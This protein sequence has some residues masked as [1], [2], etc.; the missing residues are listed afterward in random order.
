MLAHTLR[1]FFVPIGRIPRRTFVAGAIAC[2]VVFLC[3]VVLIESSAG[4]MA[5]VALYP[6]FYWALLTLGIKR[7]HDTDQAGSRL[8]LFLLPII[9]PLWGLLELTF[10]GG[11]PDENRFGPAPAS[12]GLDYLRVGHHSPNPN[13]IN[14]VTGIQVVQVA[15]IALPTTVEGVQEALNRSNGP[16][17]IGGGRFSM[18]G[19]IA[20]AGSLHIDMRGLNKVVSINPIARTVRV[21]AGVRWCDLQKVLDAHDLSVR[22]M[23]TYA[24][25]TVGGSL[26]VNCHGRYV[27]EGPLIRSVLSITLCMADGELIE[28]SP[29]SHAELFYGAIGGYGG[30][31]VV[32]E[33]ELSVTDNTRVEQT[34]Q[35]MKLEAYG[36]HFKQTVRDASTAVFHNADLYPPHY[37]AMRSVTWRTTDKYVTEPGRL[38]ALKR[39]HAM[40][41]YLFWVTSEM[42]LGKWRRQHIFEPLF[43]MASR[44]HWR[45]YEAGY[46]VA[47]LEPTSRARKTYVLQEYFVPVARFEEFARQMAEVFQRYAVNVINVS[48][49]H[50]KPDPG[51][52]LAWASEECFAFVVYYKQ[53][54]AAY[55]R[56]EVAVWTRE[57]TERVIGCGGSYYLPYQPHATVDQFH[58]AYPRAKELFALK[59]RVDPSNRFVN[60]LWD[61]YYQPADPAPV[62]AVRGDNEF[63]AIFGDDVWSDRF[64]LFLQNVYG[65]YPADRFHDLIQQ[66]CRRHSKDEAI[67][68]DIQGHLAEI[69]PALAELRLALPALRKQKRE[70]TRQ[71]LELL[72]E[73]REFNGVLE[74]GSTG[75]YVSH[76]REHASG[77]GP[78]YLLNE[79]APTMSPVD[80]VE[81]GGLKIIGQHVPMGADYAPITSDQ[82]ADDSLDLVTCFIGLH[83]APLEA[84][85][86][87]VRSLWRV[88]RP[89]G[90]LIVRDHDVRDEPMR[91]LVSLV[92]TVFNVGLKVPWA[93]DEAEFRAFESLDFWTGYLGE[94][95]LT[96]DGVRLFQ[97]HDPSKNGLMAFV[98]GAAQGAL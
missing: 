54:T 86:G 94:R 95:G 80:I 78:I 16:V 11:T 8:L 67:Y 21:Q 98:K 36:D 42:P 66:A 40:L 79:V 3:G 2:W 13:T 64:F 69:S 33:A 96:T 31:G 43:Y 92:H 48:L 7:Y 76:F 9:G 62:V 97:D 50:A 65:L 51:S 25:F 72:G 44:V 71:T 27:G 57:L 10:R 6:P 73:R 56:H 87:F 74:I 23:Q 77:R 68:R 46:D 55:Q 14:D 29:T 59:A 32:V 49:R 81:R 38:M 83:H 85:D 93:V 35:T 24:N 63:K 70:M 1:L 18:G 39:S 47:E 90:V 60:A 15:A 84:R 58:R 45:N 12:W 91:C 52:L 19:Q 37:K 22:I 26:G 20:S 30:L 53:G 88:L 82:I 4:P 61:K 89:G 17:S 34:H 28:A 5:T 75:R 41:R